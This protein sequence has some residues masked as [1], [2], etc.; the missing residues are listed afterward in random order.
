MER[1]FG[2]ETG[3]LYANYH[4][5]EWGV[6]VHNDNRLFEMLTLEGAQAGLSWETVLK[7][8]EA[9]QAAFYNFDIKKVAAMSDAQLRK[10]MLNQNLIRNRLKIFSTR[11]NACVALDIQKEFGSF[12]NHLWSFV[13]HKTTVNYWKSN[14]EVP[15]QS[16]ESS[17]LSKDLKKRGMSFVGPTIIYAFMQ[18]IGMVNDHLAD[19]PSKKIKLI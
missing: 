11:K 5:Y 18:A 13:S 9:Y 8:R 15:V 16:D 17:A 14:D 10:L 3:S 2:G 1:C 7:K 12:N 4:D 6:P 19:C